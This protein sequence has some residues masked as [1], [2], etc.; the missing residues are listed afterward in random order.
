MHSLLCPTPRSVPAVLH[1]HCGFV[2]ESQAQS[3]CLPIEGRQWYS[4]VLFESYRAG[5]ASMTALKLSNGTRESIACKAKQQ[6]TS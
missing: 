1:V 3:L 5:N 6:Q 2:A 4:L